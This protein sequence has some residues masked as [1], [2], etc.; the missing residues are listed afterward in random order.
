[1]TVTYACKP[2]PW[3]SFHPSG[4]FLVSCARGKPATRE[5]QAQK[6]GES[7]NLA[8]PM[9]L[10]DASTRFS[11]YTH[12][13]PW[14]RQRNQGGSVLWL[15]EEDEN[16]RNHHQSSIPSPIGQLPRLRIKPF[17]QSKM[18]TKTRMYPIVIRPRSLRLQQYGE[19]SL[20]KQARNS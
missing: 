14:A 9:R 11:D 10:P 5:L 20:G 15:E 16:A 7:V 2:R 1:M 13:G 17:P 4:R 18:V 6:G 12:G 19:L 8:A 3:S